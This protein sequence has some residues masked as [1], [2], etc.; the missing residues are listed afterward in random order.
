MTGILSKHFSQ[1]LLNYT[2][3]SQLDLIYFLEISQVRYFSAFTKTEIYHLGLRCIT[4]NQNCMD[5]R[6]VSL[7]KCF[8]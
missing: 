4:E 2:D 7:A 6:E 1:S 8:A 3:R 5:R